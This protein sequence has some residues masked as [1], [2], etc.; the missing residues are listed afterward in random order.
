MKTHAGH[1]INALDPTVVTAGPGLGYG[2]KKA[3]TGIAMHIDLAAK[4]AGAS[5]NVVTHAKHI[6]TSANNVV[7]RADQLLAIAKQVQAATD[8]PAAAALVS[9]MISLSQQLMAGVDTNGDGQITW[10]EGGLQQAQEHVNL[11]LAGE[12]LT[13][14]KERKAEEADKGRKLRRSATC[15]RARP[16]E[17]RKLPEGAQTAGRRKLPDGASRQT[18]RNRSPRAPTSEGTRKH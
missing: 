9:Q 16:A 2:L 7:T 3:A 4:A 13:P 5:P 10:E 12:H 17:R 6:A 14:G 8:A 18:T 15:L 1:V 11:M